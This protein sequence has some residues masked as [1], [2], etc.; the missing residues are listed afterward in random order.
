MTR[1]RLPGLIDPHVHTRE[2]GATHKEDWDTVT[3]A[4]LAGGYTTILAMPNTSP[5]VTDA[6]TL[7]LARQAAQAR[8][9]CDFGLH[10]GAGAD[11]VRSAA[12]LASQVAGLKLYLDQTYGP[13]RLSDVADVDAHFD[14][15][16]HQ[17]PLLCH[18]EGTS[19]AAVLGLAWLHQRPVHICHVSRQ[20]EVALIR[21]ARERGLAVTCEVTPHH[22][23]LTEEDIPAIGPSRS[24]VRPCLATT[25]DRDALWEALRLG[26]VDCIAT[27]HAPH[28]LV[29]K[30]G[31]S[32]PPGFPGL[33][34]A[35]A[36]MLSAMQAG[37]L[38]QERLVALMYTNPARIFRLQAQPESWIEVD[39][40][41]RW[42]AR[43]VY[44]RASWT[45]FA[46]MTL[47]G[48]VV[49]AV[50]RGTEAFRDG[51][52]LAPP[53]SGRDLFPRRG[54]TA[55]TAQAREIAASSSLEEG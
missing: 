25:A 47:T 49:R 46:G 52:V 14:R 9:R 13:L 54:P 33:E 43:T 32:P 2:P 7:A 53:G 27:D 5:P 15:W 38:S 11:N 3:S 45:P 51:R 31:Q 42:E 28:T 16:P 39:L 10:L 50:L 17:Q 29:E 26:I 1:I 4:A 44:S 8:A 18:A 21:R 34:T 36:L 48:R 6:V 55:L 24:E 23:F 22:L 40:E 30:D 19:L 20:I 41:S 37:R 12:S 35:L